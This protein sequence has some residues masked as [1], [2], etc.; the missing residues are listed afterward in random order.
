MG[1][2]PIRAKLVLD[3]EARSKLETIA[4]SR[5][6]G[7]ARIER[8]KVLLAYHAGERVTALAEAFQTNRPKIERILNRALEMGALASLEDRPGR[9]R[10]PEITAESSGLAHGCRLYEACRPGLPRRAL[11]NPDPGAPRQKT[12]T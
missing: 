6:E 8:A 3:A 1:R 2:T 7:Q 4:K 12:R 10:K 5:T 9:G 11:G